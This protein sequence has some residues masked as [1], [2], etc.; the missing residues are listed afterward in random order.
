MSNLRS[1]LSILLVVLFLAGPLAPVVRAQNEQEPQQDPL[2]SSIPWQKGP[3]TAKIGSLAEIQIPEG[4]LFGGP[5]DAQKLLQA[6]GNPTSGKELGWLTPVNH[7]WF[8][9]FEFEDIGYVKDEEKDK[10]DAASM[11]NAIKEGTNQSN[12]YRKEHGSP[13]ITITG[14]QT[15]PTYNPQTNNLEFGIRGVDSANNQILNYTVK[16][17]GRGGIMKIDLVLDP[18]AIDAVL[19]EYRKVLAGFSYTTGNKYAEY[20][21]GDKLAAYGLAALVTGGG[22]ALAATTGLLA[23]A[24]KLIVVAVAAVIG[25]IKKAFSALFG[26]GKKSADGGVPNA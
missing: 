21:S 16:V 26:R 7:A 2:L 22:V 8:V 9:V 3:T 4:Y 13:T 1:S 17:L 23:K 6:Y 12:E 25:A 15:P 18:D 14:W 20:K 10:L 24:W 5:A 11:L 19:P